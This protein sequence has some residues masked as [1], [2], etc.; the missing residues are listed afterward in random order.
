MLVSCPLNR[1][2]LLGRPYSLRVVGD[3]RKE[4]FGST[5]TVC[6]CR[7]LGFQLQHFERLW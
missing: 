3:R 1:L 6:W 2:L 4:R 7:R 5:L